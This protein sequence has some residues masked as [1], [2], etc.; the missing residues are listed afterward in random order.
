[1]PSTRSSAD[2]I[3]RCVD[4]CSE[5]TEPQIRQIFAQNDAALAAQLDAHKVK[6]RA[7]DT[8]DSKAERP[9]VHLEN[10]FSDVECSCDQCR[11]ILSQREDAEEDG[12]NDEN[13]SILVNLVSHHS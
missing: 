1:M 7:S 11:E 8:K 3:T 5:L 4:V 6:Y 12:G 13:Q 9:V 2:K 10:N